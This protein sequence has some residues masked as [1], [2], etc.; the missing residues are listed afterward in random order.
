[1]ESAESNIGNT[2]KPLYDDIRPDSI[3]YS[4]FD[5]YLDVYGVVLLY[6]QEIKDKNTEEFD[7][8]YVEAMDKYIG[9]HVV[10]T[11]KDSNPI[12]TKVRGRKKNHSSDLVGNMNK[13]PILD[14]GI[15]KI[16][17]TYGRVEEYS[18]NTI[19]ENPLE[20]VDGD[21]WDTGVLSEIVPFRS[22][23]N[24]VIQK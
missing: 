14:T 1:M 17:F 3:Y 16:E 20:K 13:N 21:G 11:R 7:G 19:M 10:V 2:Q 4:S 24:V 18:V 22:D 5:D 12:L 9:T 6:G 23:L 15:Y 8:S